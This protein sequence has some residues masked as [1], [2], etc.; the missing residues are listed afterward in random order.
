MQST[1]VVL[2]YET[3]QGLEAHIV[4]IEGQAAKVELGEEE[5]DV[6]R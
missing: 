1:T 6:G 5:G 2:E 4:T 3:S